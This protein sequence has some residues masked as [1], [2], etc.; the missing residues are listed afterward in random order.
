LA[1]EVTPAFRDVCR[2]LV[3]P[4]VRFAICSIPPTLAKQA[5]CRYAGN[6]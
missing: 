2:P 3:P 6:L 5:K 1:V 4:T